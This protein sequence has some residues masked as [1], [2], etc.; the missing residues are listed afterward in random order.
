MSMKD[1]L[2][3]YGDI[4]FCKMNPSFA[5]TSLLLVNKKKKSSYVEMIVKTKG[6]YQIFVYQENER[7]MKKQ[8]V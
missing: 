7:A 1:F 2:K 8:G 5:H 6:M 3:Y 4:S